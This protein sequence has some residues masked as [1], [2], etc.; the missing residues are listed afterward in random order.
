MRG[1]LRIW[2]DLLKKSFMKNFIFCVM[3][4]YSQHHV[5][6]FGKEI[7]TMVFSC[8]FYEFPR[9]I[10]FIQ[11]HIPWLLLPIA[12][13]KKLFFSIKDIALKAF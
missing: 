8:K 10:L 9:K 13:R 3:F 12:F 2:S 11:E 6:C 4:D 1:N 5:T 7:R